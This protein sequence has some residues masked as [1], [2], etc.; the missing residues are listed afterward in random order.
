VSI[1]E[2]IE[3]TVRGDRKWL[4]ER[5]YQLLEVFVVSPKIYLPTRVLAGLVRCSPN[6]ISPYI[7][8]IRLQI[9]R[10]SRKGQETLL[11]TKYNSDHSCAYVFFD[12][13]EEIKL[14]GKVLE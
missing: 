3:F 14:S 12:P 13:N 10:D 1:T 6:S 7:S 4:R 5:P 11:R 9:E 8:D 2:K